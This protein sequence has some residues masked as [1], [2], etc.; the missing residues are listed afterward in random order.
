M[1]ASKCLLWIFCIY[2]GCGYGDLAAQNIHV[3]QYTKRDG[4]PHNNVFDLYEDRDGIVWLGTDEGLT[5]FNGEEFQTFSISKGL[6]SSSVLQVEGF[7]DSLLLVSVYKH[8]V[9][10]FDGDRF[11]SPDTSRVPQWITTGEFIAKQDKYLAFHAGTRTRTGDP[12]AVQSDLFHI[13]WEE[14]QP[15]DLDWDSWI[16]VNPE[17]EYIYLDENE[18]VD[19]GARI[20]IEYA[21]SRIFESKGDSFYLKSCYNS[22]WKVPIHHQGPPK[23]L[24]E[25]PSKGYISDLVQLQDDGYWVGV[26]NRLFE[27]D[28]TYR[29]GQ[30]VNLDFETSIHQIAE[31][32]G[33]GVVVSGYSTSQ[34]V[35][36]DSTGQVT[37]L[38]KRLN[39]QQMINRLEVTADG[40]LWICTMGE[41]VYRVQFSEIIQAQ[42]APNEHLGKVRNIFQD[43]L[44]RIWLNGTQGISNALIESGNLEISLQSKIE[45][46]SF[47][48]CPNGKVLLF[49]EDPSTL[50]ATSHT[51]PLLPIY[52]RALPFLA[53]PQVINDSTMIAYYPNGSIEYWG[54]EDLEVNRVLKFSTEP[55]NATLCFEWMNDSLGWVGTVSGIFGVNLNTAEMWKLTDFP[56]SA[57]AK[58]FYR[59]PHDTLWVVSDQ[60]LYKYWDQQWDSLMVPQPRTDNM[61]EVMVKD[62]QGR[63]WLGTRQGLFVLEDGWWGRITERDGLFLDEV[64][65]LK[66]DHLGRMYVGGNEGVSVVDIEQYAASLS[67]QKVHLQWVQVNGEELGGCEYLEVKDGEEIAVRF[68]T[69]E[70]RDQDRLKYRYRL[71]EESDWL[72]TTQ[73]FVQFVNLQPDQYHFE[74]QVLRSTEI[75][76]ENIGRQDVLWSES[77]VIPFSVVPP[78][79]L[80]RWALLVYLLL[81][82]G[83]VFLGTFLYVRISKQREQARAE[84][85]IKVA[86][87]ELR[88][89]QAQINP[90]FLFN[91]LNTIQGFIFSQEPAAANSYLSKFSHLMRMFLESSRKKTHSL[92]SEIDLLRHYLEMES[93]SYGDRFTWSM[94]VE[95]DEDM[96][97]LFTVP[98]MLFQIYIENAI[99]RGLL[100]RETPGG[101]LSILFHV[102]E[103]ELWCVIDDNGI[104]RAR[105]EELKKS[106]KRVYQ[107]MGMK[108]TKERME[109]LKAISNMDIQFTIHDKVLPTGAPGGTRVEILLKELAE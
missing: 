103:D 39:I 43:D 94:E 90:H 105:A 65:S 68:E 7:R 83:L 50:Y 62:S 98:T 102:K 72:I 54:M 28:S 1:N 19:I 13:S 16:T 67:D 107:S 52:E 57:N 77:L 99:Q 32:P 21:R 27:V 61:A 42:T 35:L 86:E 60:H 85:A 45:G 63:I 100:N 31:V 95:G 4:L 37:D 66:E 10:L 47:L 96:L 24:L 36:L 93:I 38:G 74:V 6:K 97:D 14:G 15:F 29:I 79:H 22:L 58:Q 82:V 18:F 41:G 106:R 17:G 104:G 44:N 12:K 49:G 48:S 56:V 108:L 11:L 55:L 9:N 23:K 59:D 87:S 20:D 78:W 88:A 51:N 40:A 109:V 5:R 92:H 81:G 8:G 69:P 2:F 25:F 80:T 101:H 76:S 73:P 34:L 75:W 70:Y 30:S 26:G 84:I 64:Y 33:H 46:S 3:N 53:H 89:L 91:V 71:Q